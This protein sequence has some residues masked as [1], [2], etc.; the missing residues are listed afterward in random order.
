[1]YVCWYSAMSCK[2]INENVLFLTFLYAIFMSLKATRN[3]S[4]NDSYNK[5]SV[6]SK[7]TVSALQ[8]NGF[9][10]AWLFSAIINSSII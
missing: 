9:L 8:S 1:M 4:Y 10:L 3:K 5:K 2:H 6:Y 7:Y